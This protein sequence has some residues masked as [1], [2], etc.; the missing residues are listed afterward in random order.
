MGMPGEKPQSFRA[1]GMRLLRELRPERLPLALI[2]VAGTLSVVLAVVGPRLLGDATN[3]I[4]S[5][6]IGSRLPAGLSK[7]EVVA[8]LRA[9]GQDTFADLVS[10]M[11]VVPGQGIDTDGLARVLL[12]VVAVYVGS[13]LFGW[14]Q[15]WLA[16]GVVQDRKSTRLNSSHVKTSYA[17]FCLTKKKLDE[18]QPQHDTP[19]QYLLYP[20]SAVEYFSPQSVAGR[21]IVLTDHH[22]R[23]RQMTQED[24]QQRMLR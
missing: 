23:R 4:F 9:D 16:A 3:F 11:D 20:A 2:T 1:S 13:F 10:G 6:F 12:L 14:V 5:G 22:R 19:Q 15:G 24:V 17:V 7:D 21:V 18:A 8:G